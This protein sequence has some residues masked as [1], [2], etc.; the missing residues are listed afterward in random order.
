MSDNVD[1][2]FRNSIREVE[3]IRCISDA[4]PCTGQRERPVHVSCRPGHSGGANIAIEPTLGKRRFDRGRGTCSRQR[5]R[6]QGGPWNARARR[7]TGPGYGLARRGRLRQRAEVR[8]HGNDRQ[9]EKATKPK[10]YAYRTD[11]RRPEPIAHSY[12]WRL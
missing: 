1:V 3:L 11:A 2:T 8:P 9:K 5:A 12:T 7:R 6:T 10:T 4:C